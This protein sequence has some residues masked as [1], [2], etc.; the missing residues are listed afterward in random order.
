MIRIDGRLLISSTK[1]CHFFHVHNSYVLSDDAG[2]DNRSA[3]NKESD[4]YITQPDTTSRTDIQQFSV[5]LS[6]IQLLVIQQ[7]ELMLLMGLTIRY[8]TML[9]A[10]T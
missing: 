9:L 3:A 8:K 5:I 10:L 6:F 7:L 4:T 1:Y 2:A